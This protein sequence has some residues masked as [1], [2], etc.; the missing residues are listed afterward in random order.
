MGDG[1]A[2][3]LFIF[4]SGISRTAVC[5]RQNGLILGSFG[6]GWKK[7]DTTTRVFRW[8]AVLGVFAEM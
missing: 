1:I 2:R 4:F 3:M 5:T 8:G 7:E 6:F